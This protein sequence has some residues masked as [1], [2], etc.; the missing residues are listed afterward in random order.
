MWRRSG[1]STYGLSG[2]K[3]EEEHPAMAYTPLKDMAPFTF[4]H[5]NLFNLFNYCRPMHE[6]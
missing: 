2:L 6:L 3:K 1:F 5:I 4:Y